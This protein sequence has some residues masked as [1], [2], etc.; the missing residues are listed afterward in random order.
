MTLLDLV[1]SPAYAQA[2]GQSA[3]GGLF[4]GGL[5]GLMLPIILVGVMYFLMIRPQMKRAKEHR[6]MLEKLGNGDEVITNGGIAGVVREIGDSFISIEVADN[7]RLRV[8][9][10]AIANVLPK[11]TLKSA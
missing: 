10:G 2:A 3:P 11:G 1:V 9:K 6:A 8:Q 7:V 4:G 5:S